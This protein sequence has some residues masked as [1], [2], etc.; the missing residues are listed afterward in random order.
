MVGAICSNDTVPVTYR[1]DR[2]ER[3]HVAGPELDASQ[4]A[5]VEHGG[6]PL[7]V[8]AGPGTGKTTTLVEAVVDRVEKR[9][10]SPDQVLVLT[11][12]RKAADELRSRITARLGRTTSTPISSTFHAFC[13]GLVR[14]FQPDAAYQTPLRLLSAPEQDVR[15]AELLA[16]SAESRRA[17]WPAS[18]EAALPTRGF[19]RETHAVLARA[20]ELGLDP[21]D[22]ERIGRD[23]GVPEWVAAGQFME[24][25][26]S[27]LDQQQVLDYAE[28]IHR[29]VLTAEQPETIDQLRRQ[30]RAVFVDEYQDTDKSQVRLLRALAGDGRDIVA[31][32]DPD[33]SIYAFR[34]ADVRGILEFPTQFRR[35][36][37]SAAPV[38][39]LGTTRRFGARLLTASRRIANGIGVSGSIPL[40]A[41]QTFR[42]P[43]AAPNAYGDGRAD[44]FTFSSSGAETDHIADLLRRAHLEDGIAWSDMAVLVRSGVT[45]IAGLRRA[46]V[47]AGVP[48]E[49]AGDEVPLRSEPAVQPLL[50]ALRAV[51]DPG[52]LTPEVA[53]RLVMSPLC[54][55]DAAQVRKLG[56]E[57]RRRDREQHTGR[58]SP[59]ASD[60][61]VRRALLDP[62]L[63]DGVAHAWAARIRT[64]AGLLTRATVVL[65]DGDATE[66][67][68]WVLW[69]GTS[70][71]YRLRRAVE[72]G[73]VAARTAHRDLDAV[74]ELFEVAARTEEQRDHTAALVFLDEVQAQQIPADTLAERG[75]RGDAVRLLT[76]HR[77]KG[78][79]W[80]LVVVA[81]VQEGSWPDLRRRG[82][83]LQADRLGADGVVPPRATKAMMAEERR[84]FYVAVSRARQRL[85][86]TA[87]ASP[88]ADGDQPSRLID[89]LGLRPQP[90][91]GRPGRTLSLP[92]LVSELRQVTADPAVR[93]PLR[94]AA[95]ARLARLA[96]TQVAGEPVAPAADPAAWW[97]LRDRTVSDTPVR[98]AD[99]PLRISASTL[100][101]VLQCPLQWFLS[102]EAAGESGRTTRLGFGSVIHV[103]ADHMSKGEEVDEQRLLALL[104]SVWDQLHFESPWIAAREHSAAQQAIRRFV[105]WADGR[106]DR[107]YLGSE[108]GFTVTV[109]LDDG[110][111]VSLRGTVD[112]IERDSDGS[113]RVIDF[114]TGSTKPTGPSLPND[115]Q[116]GLYQ[117]A[118]DEGGLEALCGTGAV[119]GGAELVQLR[120]DDAGLPKVQGQA[121]QL[122]DD[123]GRKPV[124][125]QLTTAAKTVRSEQ[126]DA[127]VN[128]HCGRCAFAAMCPT[129]QRGGPV[130]S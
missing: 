54:N 55:L 25:Y 33:Q 117:L 112:R 128:P 11:F 21:D 7:L 120:F 60:E 46:L 3:P 99:E 14:Q 88:E 40:D 72:A 69:S 37:G 68:L 105:A 86:V 116:L 30:F 26:L 108:E 39:A 102:R 42:N 61:L 27:V 16:H 81:G 44:V 124:E 77:S 12:S 87:V 15:L 113:I 91:P 110:D 18:V 107:V 76:A 130:L 13:Y 67:A 5:V 101:G 35:A 10:L 65:G 83:L 74:C 66:Q 20:R 2:A 100:A 71:P 43:V 38:V 4:R 126:F 51:A 104:D 36:D 32:G 9:G 89:E 59:Y 80:R 118:V 8:L 123:Q 78:L 50:T 56:R 22:L 129:Q 96:D 103:L 127:T 47:G 49:V 1:L 62:E 41:F 29:A 19:A 64:L 98:P 48:V 85:V 106:A 121:P 82:T 53:H 97:G 95:A 70:W 58:R 63:L 92:G 115:P 94:R 34:G 109:A 24:E 111:A 73:G 6:G 52:S 17:Q 45:S 79:E 28:V 31:V 93:E 122:P 57:L 119:S 114:K 90:R 23:H 75:V 84:L 125:V